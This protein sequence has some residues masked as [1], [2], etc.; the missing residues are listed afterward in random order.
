MKTNQAAGGDVGSHIRVIAKTVEQAGV[1]GDW[2]EDRGRKR[3]G[4]RHRIQ[5]AVSS[6]VLQHREATKCKNN[7]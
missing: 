5:R 7:I 2:E 6:G 1:T 4:S 3:M